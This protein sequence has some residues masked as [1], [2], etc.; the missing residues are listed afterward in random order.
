MRCGDS[1]YWK[2]SGEI[3]NELMMFPVCDECWSKISGEQKHKYIEL[4]VDKWLKEGPLDDHNKQ[5][6]QWAHER[7][8]GHSLTVKE[9]LYRELDRVK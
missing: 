3:G 1:W 9:R 2:S 8:D 4:L 6:V 7:I 5:K